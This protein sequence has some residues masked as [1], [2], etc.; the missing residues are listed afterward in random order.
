MG[1]GGEDRLRRDSL[2]WALAHLLKNGDTDLLPVPF[3]YEAIKANWKAI[4]PNLELRDLRT[5]EP[6]A[7]ERFLVPKPEGAFRVV[8][9]LDPIDALLYTAAVYECAPI[10]ETARARREVACAYRI[11][12]APDGRLF[13]VESAWDAFTAES[14]K[15]MSRKS[16]K[17]VVTADI[18]DFYSQ[19]GH[20][21]V[22][23]ALEAAGVAS[24]RAQSIERILSGWSALQSRGVPVGPQASIVLAEAVLMDVDAYLA[25]HSYRHVRFVDDFRIFCRSEKEAVSAMHDLC[26][27]LFT[28]HRRALTPSKTRTYD[29][30][31]F[32]RKVLE[33]PE[34]L[35]RRTKKA[36]VKEAVDAWAAA[37]YSVGE[38]EVEKDIKDV[39]VLVRLFS[40]CVADRP[41]R[42][43]LTRYLLRQ[44]ARL[45]TNEIQALTLDNLDLLTPVL[46]DAFIY[47]GKAKQKKSVRVV[48]KRLVEFG[49]KS[50]HSFM[51]VVQEWMVWAACGFLADV[52]SAS[53]MQRV[54]S[55]AKLVRKDRAVAL[56]APARRDMAWVRSRKES[57]R[58]SGPWEKRA[59]IAA[60]AILSR[61]ERTAWKKSILQTQDMLDSAVA[62]W[63]LSREE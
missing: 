32:R 26:D 27:Y 9:R 2:E 43:G 5:F 33:K 50:S 31:T 22:T 58:N 59:I 52:L 13:A 14:V 24:V 61:D 45:R 57:W 4:L 15:F 60:G 12:P 53:Q 30:S 48:A 6:G 20:H 39:D 3:E 63:A 41:L 36:M 25:N 62:M 28:A 55:A 29:A 17:Y 10:V 16:I 23:N 18:S 56:L 21:R 34:I 40:E 42:V 54:L 1:K 46:R 7:L 11:D 47:L 37:G 19:I 38:D 8:M 51:Q 44:A 49:T 35:E